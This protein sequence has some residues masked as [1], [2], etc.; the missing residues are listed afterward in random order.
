[1]WVP[2]WVVSVTVSLEIANPS[3]KSSGASPSTDAPVTWSR[4]E[5]S[6]GV[7]SLAVAFVAT[8]RSMRCSAAKRISHRLCVLRLE[9]LHELANG[10]DRAQLLALGRLVDGHSGDD[11]HELGRVDVQVGS[12]VGIGGDVVVGD[13]EL[14][15]HFVQAFVDGNVGVA[16][17]PRHFCWLLG[18]MVRR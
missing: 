17:G 16:G 13:L 1:M 12:Q 2:V 10:G 3:T 6:T 9:Q 7:A 14:G 4:T 11:L 5:M 8:L 15:E 18:L